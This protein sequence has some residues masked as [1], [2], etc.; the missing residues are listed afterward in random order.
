M[1]S[2]VSLG[3][4]AGVPGPTGPAGPA[5]PAGP[6]GADASAEAPRLLFDP[7]QTHTFTSG[8]VADVASWWGT[9]GVWFMPWTPT[10]SGDLVLVLP[11]NIGDTDWLDFDFWLFKGDQPNVDYP[12]RVAVEGFD[13]DATAFLNVFPAPV[14]APNA[15]N[16]DSGFVEAGQHY[17]VA[18]V[19][20]SG[21]PVG[22]TTSL[23]GVL[24][25]LYP[26]GGIA[27]VP[28]PPPEGV[29]CIVVQHPNGD[30][31]A[32][33]VYHELGVGRRS[34]DMG[35]GNQATGQY[36]HAQGE[37][38]QS[39]GRSS[40]VEGAMNHATAYASHAEGWMSEATAQAAHAEG[41]ITHA[42]EIGAHAEGHLTTASGQ[43]AHAEGEQS[44]A[45]GNYSHAEGLSTHAAGINSHA[46]GNNTNASGDASHAEGLNT[47]A[48]GENSHAEGEGTHA[49]GRASHASG[50]GALA[51]RVGEHAEGS[52][53]SVQVS[54]FMLSTPSLPDPFSNGDASYVPLTDNRLSVIR[55]EVAAWSLADDLA[56][57]WSVTA[58]A[59]KKSGI[60]RLVAPADI[61]QT[62]QDVGTETWQLTLAVESG[63]LVLRGAGPVGVHG[64]A[65]AEVV[66]VL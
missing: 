37:D 11:T 26:F 48:S 8:D 15:F 36:S 55:L 41:H 50:L 54:R 33:P 49:S 52:A 64:V 9:A 25:S 21:D 23:D 46:E 65:L 56:S 6:P 18:V 42:T 28:P 66:E 4:L 40:H 45:T 14:G 43:F 60:V 16:L 3:Q 57:T 5:G 39:S 12:D 7:G 24:I 35:Y 63:Q 62:A 38:N 32:R 17:T 31:A 44:V 59:S 22:H 53:A 2:W 34:R 30:L 1:P 20:W 10:V 61:T 58:T 51:W 13:I 19:D 29:D 47:W 27:D